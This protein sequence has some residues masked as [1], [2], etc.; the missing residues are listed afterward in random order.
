MVCDM[1][2][3]HN[4]GDRYIC[5]K[6]G[7]NVLAVYILETIKSLDKGELGKS[8]YSGKTEAVLHKSRKGSEVDYLE[9]LVAGGITDESEDESRNIADQNT[10]DEGDEL[11]HFLAVGR[12]ENDYKE[13]DESAD[14]ACPGEGFAAVCG[15]IADSVA[16]EGKTDD[17]NG[18]SDYYRG[19]KLIY[20]LYT[21]EFDD[22][23]DDGINKTCEYR[24]DDETC[25]AGFHGN[26]AAEGCEH[27]ADKREGR[28][29]KY[30]A[31][32]RCEQKVDNSSDAC[33][34][35]CGGRCH[36][37]ADDGRHCDGCGEDR[38]HLLYCKDDQLAE[39][40]FVFDIVVELHLFKPPNF[41]R[42]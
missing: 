3:E 35:H 38:K 27:R 18:R 10:D 25:V 17:R 19:H 28:A 42:C 8:N 22:K 36:T 34:E 15:S 11:D 7:E 5:D 37:V 1:L 9:R 24:T 31:L 32:E 21:C 16:G 6:N 12:A 41:L 30:R 29:E 26:G 33:T 39:L 20:P 14:K 23:S 4:E 13:G 2:C 40:G